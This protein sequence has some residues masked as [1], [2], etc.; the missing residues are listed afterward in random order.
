MPLTMK[1]VRS[2]FVSCLEIYWEEEKVC[3]GF[4]SIF[5]RVSA[6]FTKQSQSRYERSSSSLFFF[7]LSSFIRGIHAPFYCWRCFLKNATALC[8]ASSAASLL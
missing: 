6:Q 2:Y 8:H 3:G 1:A 7:S 5:S 4:F